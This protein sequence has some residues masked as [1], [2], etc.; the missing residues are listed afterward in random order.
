MTDTV[1]D[2]LTDALESLLSK[3]VGSSE[4]QA[5][6]GAVGARR[7]GLSLAGL[8]AESQITVEHD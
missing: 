3:R 6:T 7:P 5:W 2:A 8:A 4:N 1:N